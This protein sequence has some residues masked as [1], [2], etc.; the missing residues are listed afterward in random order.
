MADFI[1]QSFGRYHIIE[2]LGEGGMAVVYKAYDTRLESEV[3]IKFIRTERL[4]PEVAD[5]ALKRFEREAKALA[6]LS[7]PNIVRVTD[8]GEQDGRPYLVMPYLSGG[9]LKQKLQGKPMAWREA[10]RLLLPI[11]EALDYAHHQSILHRDIKSSNILITDS[12][13]PMLA[14]FGV[15]KLFEAED[16]VDLTGTGVGIGTPEYMAPEQGRGQTDVRSEVYSLGVVFYE[17]ITGRKPYTADT[18][19]A[20]L[21]MQATDPL[22]PPHKFVPNLPSDVEGVIYKSLAKTPDARYQSMAEFG[23]ALQKVAAEKDTGLGSPRK[24]ILSVLTGLPVLVLM[25]LG[26]VLGSKYIPVAIS[27]NTATSTQTSTEQVKTLSPVLT[28]SQL[29]TVDAAT[30]LPTPTGKLSMVDDFESGDLHDFRNMSGLWDIIPDQ[31]NHVLRVTEDQAASWPSIQFGPQNFSNGTIQYRF[32]ITEIQNTN[33][34]SGMVYVNFRTNGEGISDGYTFQIQMN[35]T[36]EDLN[37]VSPSGSDWPSLGNR[38]IPV[39]PNEWHTVRV[40]VTDSIFKVFLDQKP[41][42]TAVDNKQ[43]LMMGRLGFQGSPQTTILFDDVQ[44]WMEE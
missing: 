14:D 40:E 20:V 30:V 6:K 2:K 4:V 21:I 3:A 43:R 15:A 32:N 42:L 17:L 27:L 7:H 31:G 34:Q 35:N 16:T 25:I 19:L 18:P 22:Q 9:T 11:A 13:A 29:I 5:K 39:S 1:G 10:A 24:K 44:V 23:E 38:S 8:Y 41:L 12:G 26:I 36:L 33:S 28:A 37:Y